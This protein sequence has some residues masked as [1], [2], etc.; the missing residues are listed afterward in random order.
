MSCAHLFPGIDE[1]PDVVP[2]LVLWQARGAAA[3]QVRIELEYCTDVPSF[4]QLS[5]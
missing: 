1:I 4:V 2:T 3:V 5:L